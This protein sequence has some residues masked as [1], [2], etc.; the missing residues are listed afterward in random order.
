MAK[1]ARFLDVAGFVATEDNAVRL[2]G[3]RGRFALP[4]CC[5]EL[6]GCTA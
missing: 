6:S 5:R 4:R 2:P 3:D 1:I